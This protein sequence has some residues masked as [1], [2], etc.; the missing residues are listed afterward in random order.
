MAK[1]PDPELSVLRCPHCGSSVSWWW[2]KKTTGQVL[3]DA[4]CDKGKILMKPEDCT[5]DD[6]RVEVEFLEEVE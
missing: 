3:C 1:K 4:K 6:G 2:N 5:I